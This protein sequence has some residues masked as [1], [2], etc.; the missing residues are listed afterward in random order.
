MEKPNLPEIRAAL[1]DVV[2]A[3]ERADAIMQRNRE[4]FQHRKVQKT[5]LSVND[6]IRDVLVLAGTQV[7]RSQCT[8]VTHLAD[9][10]PQVLGDRVE[11][12]QVLLNLVVNATDAIE[13]AGSSARR[14]EIASRPD[15]HGHVEVAVRDNGIGF[16]GVDVGRLFTASYTTKANG[17]GVGLSICK[18]IIEAHEGRLWAERNPERGATFFFSLPAESPAHAGPDPDGEDR[19][20][21]YRS[22]S[23]AVGP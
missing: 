23:H 20:T 11:L 14:V 21:G 10:L 9:H 7:Q 2:D 13:Q 4:L 22:R 17:T 12:Q 1:L 16:D 18:A 5:S 6:V 15:G 8:L 19:A 3:G